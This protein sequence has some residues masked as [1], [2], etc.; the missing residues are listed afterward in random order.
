MAEYPIPAWLQTRPTDV[1]EIYLNARKAGAQLDMERQRMQ[2]Q[3]QQAEQEM[4]L[5]RDINAQNQLRQ[6]QELEIEKARVNAETGLK[7]SQMELAH[8]KLKQDLQV[9]GAQLNLAQQ[10]LQLTAQ[11]AARKAA[12]QQEYNRLIELGMQ[13]DEAA[14][15]V[16]P[17]A[18]GSMAGMGELS[19]E[20]QARTHPFQPTTT[21]VDGEKLIQVSPQRFVKANAAPSGVAGDV[22]SNAVLDPVTKKPIPGMVAVPGV[23]GGQIVKDVPKYESQDEKRL[24]ALETAHEKDTVGANAAAMDDKS[25]SAYGKAAKKK[26]LDR[27]DQILKLRDKIDK[28][29]QESAPAQPAAKKSKAQRANELAQQHPDWDRAKII[30]AVNDEFAQ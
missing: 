5:K 28:A 27:E 21:N 1:A 6:Q 15:R 14:L 18:F 11:A 2:Q 10:K 9:K 7:Q 25:I 20:Y 24:K 23:R 19:K 17:S 12:A 13:P 3:Q 22:Q 16:G 29:Q 4:A 8:E 26:Y 30:K